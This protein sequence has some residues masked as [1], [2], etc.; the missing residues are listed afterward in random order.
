[1]IK[2]KELDK[3]LLKILKK[4]PKGI[5]RFNICEILKLEK[6]EY[7]HIVNGKYAQTLI[8]HHK[9][10][11]IYD[12]LDSLKIE[13]KITNYLF[14]SGSQGKPETYWKLIK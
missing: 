13:G 12:H 3:I 7:K 14:H 4:H 5:N 11:T 6:Y 1:M 9:R 2:N 8:L 10:T